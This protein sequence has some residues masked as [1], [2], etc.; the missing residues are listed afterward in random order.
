MK[1]IRNCDEMPN[2]SFKDL[3]N[4]ALLTHI[5]LIMIIPIFASVF[6]GNW[7]DK[8]LGTNNIFLLIFVIL[9]VIISFLNLY[10]FTVKRISDDSDEDEKSKRD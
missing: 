6:A 2:F 10:R 4:L 5:A 8:K 9:G 3:E 7:I 1:W